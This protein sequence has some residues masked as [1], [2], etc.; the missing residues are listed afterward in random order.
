MLLRFNVKNFLSFDENTEFSMFSG[1]ARMKENHLIKT[2]KTNLLKFAAIYGANAAGKS[3]LVKAMFYSK[4]IIIGS[5][6]DASRDYYFKGNTENKDKHTTFEYEIMIGDRYYAYGFNIIISKKEICG[7]WLY[8]ITNN[9][10]KLIF[11]R[12]IDENH[13]EYGI[14][15]ANSG[16]KTRFDIYFEDSKLNKKSLFLN[17]IN[18]NKQTLY[19]DH[20]EFIIFKEIY[21]WFDEYLDLNFASAPITNFQYMLGDDVNFNESV[22]NTLNMFGTGITNFNL[23][24]SD[25]ADIRKD[26]PRELLEDVKEELLKHDEGIK[27]VNIRGNKQFYNIT[28]DANNN[29]KVKTLAFKHENQNGDFYLSDESDG[30]R[31][32]MDLIE[33]LLNS[34]NKVFVIDEI[35]R[36]LHPNLT[37]KFIELFLEVAECK[38]VQL[39]VTTHEDRVLDLDLLRRDEVWFAE[40]DNRGRTELYSLEDFTPRFDTKIVKAYLEGRYGAVPHFKNLNIEKLNKLYCDNN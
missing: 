15:F 32:L 27:G 17:E 7:E 22:V 34:K 13:F 8:D 4:N 12:N 20:N 28:L 9:D 25:I 37:Y 16:N 36:S 6:S 40:K 3:N 24:E 29:L 18:R 33:I 5:M 31:R 19:E 21:A 2:K 10:E 14:K 38:N 26:L 11:E 1:K 39:I 23:I 30:T 35:D